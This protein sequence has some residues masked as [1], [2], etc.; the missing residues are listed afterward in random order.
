M[1]PLTRIWGYFINKTKEKKGQRKDK[2]LTSIKLK[3]KYFS[4]SP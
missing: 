1:Y 4:F 2:R 3:K